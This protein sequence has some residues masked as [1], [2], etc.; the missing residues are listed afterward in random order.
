MQDNSKEIGKLANAWAMR[1]H[2]RLAQQID[3]LKV[4]Q[5]GD[6]KAGLSFQ[7]IKKPEATT[8][9]FKFRTYG[10][11]VDRGTGRGRDSA[12]KS[13]RKAKRWYS[14][15]FFKELAVLYGAVGYTMTE[16][17]IRAIKKIQ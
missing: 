13:S 4:I 17:T 15:I 3:M 2:Q 7:V 11:F 9:E 5:S 16:Q 6:L 12:K 1:T 8:I 10:R 14:K